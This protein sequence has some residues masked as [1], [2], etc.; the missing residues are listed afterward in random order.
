MLETKFEGDELAERTMKPPLR[1]IAN[2]NF[3]IQFDFSQYNIEL[4]EESPPVVEQEVN[5]E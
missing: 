4:V 3:K 2:N 1:K 5:E